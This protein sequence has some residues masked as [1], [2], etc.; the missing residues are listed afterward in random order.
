MKDADDEQDTQ[1]FEDRL[2]GGRA[3]RQGFAAWLFGGRALRRVG[4]RFC[5]GAA[6]LGGARGVGCLLRI[7]CHVRLFRLVCPIFLESEVALNA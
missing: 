4:G 1:D 2:C 6:W 5:N 7:A 3:S